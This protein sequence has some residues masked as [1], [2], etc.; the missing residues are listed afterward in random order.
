MIVDALKAQ[1]EALKQIGHFA[2]LERFVLKHGV[3]RNGTENVRPKA[4]VYIDRHAAAM[5]EVAGIDEFP[6][7][8]FYPAMEAAAIMCPE[9]PH[10]ILANPMMLVNLTSRRKI[11][12]SL[13]TNEKAVVASLTHEL[14][15]IQQVRSGRLG[16]TGKPLEVL[17]DGKLYPDSGNHLPFEEYT[18]LPWEVDADEASRRVVEMI[19]G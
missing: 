17:F 7:V 9:A 11:D 8:T 1:V 3:L 19:W 18:K 6:T 13:D 5:A 16:S 15:H 2:L 4:L 12:V 10:V 14:R